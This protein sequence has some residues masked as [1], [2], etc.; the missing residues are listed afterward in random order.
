MPDRLSKALQ[1]RLLLASFG[2]L[3]A[4]VAFA[5]SRL[6]GL[7]LGSCLT[8]DQAGAAHCPWCYVAAAFLLLSIMPL[9]RRAV[10][11]RTA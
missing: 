9:P 1:I 8:A 7:A 5:L 10:R 11:A 4:A 3:S 6:S 2:A